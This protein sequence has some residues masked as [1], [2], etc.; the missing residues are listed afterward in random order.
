MP[1]KNRPGHGKPWLANVKRNRKTHYI[2]SFN[3]REE[4]VA[5]EDVFKA[6]NPGMG[7]G[8][9]KHAQQKSVEVRKQKMLEKQQAIPRKVV[10]PQSSMTP[11]E[12][13]IERAMRA[14]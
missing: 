14:M 12:R 3:T 7:K 9:P 10:V 1:S 2:G 6:A 13:A 11:H 4:A 5:A 8:W